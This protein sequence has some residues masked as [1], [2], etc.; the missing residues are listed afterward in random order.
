MLRSTLCHEEDP[1]DFEN[2][3]GVAVQIEGSREIDDEEVFF[4]YHSSQCHPL[5]IPKHSFWERVAGGVAHVA[6]LGIP[7]LIR[8]LRKRELPWPTFTS[9]DEMCV[10][11]Q[12]SP[13]SDGCMEVGTKYKTTLPTGES[14]DVTVDHTNAMEDNLSKYWDISSI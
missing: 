9:K 12:K 3:I 8:K 11:C 5:F 14:V 7:M 1:N 6:T 4:P 2:R 13:G 10:K